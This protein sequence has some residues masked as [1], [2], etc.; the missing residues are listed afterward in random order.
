MRRV[1]DILLGPLCTTRLYFRSQEAGVDKKRGTWDERVVDVAPREWDDRYRLMVQRTGNYV[2]AKYRPI[3]T[4]G[5][6][7]EAYVLFYYQ[8][9]AVIICSSL[10]F[11]R[12]QWDSME[13]ENICSKQFS[14]GWGASVE[15]DKT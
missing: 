8:Y 1:S 7:N 6:F 12:V 3:L 13:W 5:E 10:R 14:Q 9:T 2:S 15:N 4:A 11:G